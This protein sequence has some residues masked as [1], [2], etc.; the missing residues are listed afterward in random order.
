[1]QACR[2]G[3]GQRKTHLHRWAKNYFSHLGAQTFC[4][5]PNS[6]RVI[7]LARGLCLPH[8]KQDMVDCPLNALALVLKGEPETLDLYRRPSSTIDDLVVGLLIQRF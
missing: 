6:L 8:R 5:F 2:W 3:R 7:K 4:D 1:M